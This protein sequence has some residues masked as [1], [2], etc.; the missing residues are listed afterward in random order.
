MRPTLSIPLLLSLISICSSAPVPTDLDQLYS[1]TDD[2]S[3]ESAIEAVANGFGIPTESAFDSIANAVES[4]QSDYDNATGVYGT[5]QTLSQNPASTKTI[6]SV[7]PITSAAPVTENGKKAVNLL[8]DVTNIVARDLQA[9]D[10]VIITEIES[11]V[12]TQMKTVSV[13]ACDPTSII[14]DTP[15]VAADAVVVATVTAVADAYVTES[16]DTTVDT[17]VTTD[18]QTQVHVVTQI[19]HVIVPVKKKQQ[20]SL[21]QQLLKSL[22]QPHHQHSPQ[23]QPPLLLLP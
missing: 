2:G 19:V 4:V 20:L 22:F 10:D 17:T 8:Q 9:R 14:S 15:S 18:V 3:I 12:V 1:L 6:V 21:Q 13:E 11:E 23:T 7:I 5:F 16:I